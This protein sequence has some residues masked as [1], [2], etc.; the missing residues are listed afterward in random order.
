MFRFWKKKVL[1]GA[2]GYDF[3]HWVRYVQYQEM[4]AYMRALPVERMDALEISGGKLWRQ[5]FPFRSFTEAHFP[6]Y[7]LCAG[8]LGERKFDVVILDHVLPH[9]LY[10]RRACVNALAMLKPGGR[11]LVSS[12][13]LIHINQ[14]TDCS[15]WSA[16]GL[17][18]LLMDAG[19]PEDGIVTG[20]WGN[21]SAVKVNLTRLG[22]KRGWFRS[23]KNDPKYPTT[24][25]AMAKVPD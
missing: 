2:L 5:T 12:S 17:R 20:S 3:T 11:F 23:L 8:P 16:M 1:L 14:A 6:D 4:F 13:F 15:R 22:E 19:F 9:V 21:L 25:W 24:S 10:P 18:H 7:D